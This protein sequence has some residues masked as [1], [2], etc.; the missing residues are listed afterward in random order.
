MASPRPDELVL[1]AWAAR[2]EGEGEEWNEVPRRKESFF[3]Q[4]SDAPSELVFD[5]LQPFS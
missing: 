4:R 3:A 5:R 2:A 1:R